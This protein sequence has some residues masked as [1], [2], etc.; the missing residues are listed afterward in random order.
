MNCSK[1]NN[2][3]PF[4]VTLSFP[5]FLLVSLI[6]LSF[7]VFVC[8]R[9]CQTLTPPIFFASYIFLLSLS[10]I[11]N[12]HKPCLC[13]SL[14]HVSNNSEGTEARPLPDFGTYSGFPIPFAAASRQTHLSYY[15]ARR[16]TSTHRDER[17]RERVRERRAERVREIAKGSS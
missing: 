7:T 5:R 10:V 2:P 6:R 3:I 13:L 17:E 11:R 16:L 4:R 1:T 8:R 9:I 12:L 15:T 14:S